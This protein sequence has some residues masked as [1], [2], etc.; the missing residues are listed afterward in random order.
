MPLVVCGAPLGNAA[1]A[2]PRLGQVLASADVV[3]AE[4]TRRL[5]RLAADLGV[6]LSGRVV[7]CFEANEAARVPALLA[8]LDSGQT[9]ALVT[10]AG[11]P[12]VSDPGFR[13]VSAAAAAGHRVTVVPGPSAA[14]A[15][16]AVSGLPSDRVVFEGF[17]PRSAGG[18]RARLAALALEPRTLVIF[19]SPRRVAASLAALAAAFGP[20]RPAVLARELTKTYE[21]VL[22]GT[23]G[24]LAEAVAAEPVRGEVTLVIAGAGAEGGPGGPGGAGAGA[25]DLAAAVAERE[26]AG[27]GR[28]E[29]MAAVAA[30]AGVSRRVVYDAV[31]RARAPD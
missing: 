9:V 27:A 18:R 8:A 11:M 5:R 19:E 7:S 1:D 30:A 25:V 31:L 24:S 23:L 26:R 14:T 17:L 22:R 20:E 2:S 28:K 13:L 21:Q 12:T 6:R 29:A 15:A 16:L 10:D 4:D 3:A